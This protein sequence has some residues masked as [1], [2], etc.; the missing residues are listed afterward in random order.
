[1]REILKIDTTFTEQ[2]KKECGENVYL[3]YQCKKCTF[4]C[5]TAYAM[6]YKPHQL[7]RA[8]Q[9][10]QKDLVLKDSSIWLCL[11][12]QTCMTRC[13][14][15]LD[16]TKVADAVRIIGQREG[17]TVPVPEIE[18]FNSSFLTLVERFGRVYEVGL[19]TMIK[20]KTKEIMKDVFLG[21]PLF[22]KG[23]F[24]LLPHRVRDINTVRKI[25]SKSRELE[26]E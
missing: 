13:P 7:I 10:G 21:I 18:A 6:G 5:P 8:I 9:L 3:C 14:Q 22:F 26:I 4:G 25:F 16:F 12:C 1:M 20:L 2:I 19:V 17:Y 15:N 23:K 24:K 11:S